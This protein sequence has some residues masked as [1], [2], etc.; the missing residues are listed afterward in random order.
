MSSFERVP[1]SAAQQGI[2]YAQ[3]LV[4][5]LPFHIGQYVEIDGP[6]DHELLDR[7]AR[8]AARE[9]AREFQTLHVRLRELDD[10][11]CQELDPDP[12][13]SIPLVD[14]GSE[15]D[16]RAAA[17][18]WI[19]GRLRDALPL[20]ATRLYETA[21]LRLS[22]GLHWWFLRA[23]HVV[24]DGYSASL[25]GRRMAEVYTALARGGAHVPAERGCYRA[26]L[27]EESAYRASEKFEGDRAY[28]TGALADKPVPVGLSDAMADPAIDH[29]TGT[30]TLS[31]EATADLAAGA[32]RLRTA[33]AGLTIAATAAY[34]ARMTGAQDVILGLAVTGRVSRL[35]LETPSMSSTVLPLRVL[36]RPDMTVHELVRT[37]TRATARLLRHQR[38][39]RDDLLRDLGLLGTRHRLHGPVI[40]VM[41]FDYRLDFA[42]T[43]GRM[44][45][46]MTWPIDDLEINVFDNLDGHGMRVGFMAHPA[47][48]T[49]DQVTAHQR[50]YLRL[51]RSLGDADPGSRLCDM[52]V[53]DRAERRPVLVGRDEDAAARRWCV[54]ELFEARVAAAPASTAV[55]SEGTTLTY[56]E[57]N[58]RANRLARSLVERGTGPGDVVAVAV[59]MER[60]PTCSAASQPGLCYP[61]T[62][63]MSPTPPVPRESPKRRSSRIRALSGSCAGPIMSGGRATTS[64]LTLPR[65]RSTRRHSRSGEPCSTGRVSRSSRRAGS[66]STSWDVFCRLIGSPCCCCRRACSTRW[67]TQTSQP[68]KACATCWPGAMCCPLP[69]AGRSEIGFRQSDCSMRTGP[70]RTPRSP[71]SAQSRRSTWGRARACRSAA[72]FAIR[73]C[74]CWTERCGRCR[75]ARSASCT[76]PAR[77]SRKITWDGRG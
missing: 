17:T 10:V 45:P 9:F 22:P 26:L 38:Y 68:C 67:W 39:R 16:P 48:Y 58:A 35:T 76:R 59:A 25:I 32:R 50:R 30:A 33:T 12:S 29:L 64:S 23:H 47:L 6:F 36:V 63:P 57:L 61:S 42:G 44:H 28:W 13:V 18:A 21:L 66:P 69:D 8:I 43:P 1:L 40:N 74:T 19:N 65:S 71:P 31:P 53:L 54:P 56:G 41:A 37:V 5:H 7:S 77:V 34:V 24:L 70:P 72:R 27:A 2:W 20:D 15:Q 55:V 60:S 4:P 52:D 51:L 3:Q 73:A 14:V 46:L 11:V 75:W 49:S 62:R